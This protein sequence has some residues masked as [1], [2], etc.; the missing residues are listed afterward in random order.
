[1]AI[2]N[3]PE[4]LQAAFDA[5]LNSADPHA[6]LPDGL[7]KVVSTPLK[8]LCLVLGAGKAAASMALALEQYAQENW[9]EAKLEGM[10]ITR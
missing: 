10:I 3:T 7:R 5:A 8:G 1:M 9:P 6:M 2:K 4:F